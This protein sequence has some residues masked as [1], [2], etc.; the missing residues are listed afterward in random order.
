MLDWLRRQP[1]L[2]RPLLWPEVPKVWRCAT[3]ADGGVL[4]VGSRGACMAA[5]DL[6]RNSCVRRWLWKA[7]YDKGSA[8]V[9]RLV[10]K[11]LNS[12]RRPRNTYKL[13]SLSETGWPAATNSSN[14]FLHKLSYWFITL[15]KI[16]K[17]AMKLYNMR[18]WG[19]SEGSLKSVPSWIR[20]LAANKRCRISMDREERRTLR[21]NWSCCFQWRKSG[22]TW[23]EVPSPTRTCGDGHMLEPST[24][25]KTPWPR[26]Y[27][28]I[29]I[30]QYK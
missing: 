13:K 6:W 28:S 1:P 4:G 7:A 23:R 5:E 25:L 30:C 27:G 16:L 10:T 26:R 8:L 11:S 17:R 15:V 12:P 19:G 2:K 20:A 24:K 29:Y 22:F 9:I 18:V 3:R 21:I 14:K